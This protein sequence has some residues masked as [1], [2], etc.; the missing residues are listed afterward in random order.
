[1]RLRVCV[2]GDLRRALEW[3][4]RRSGIDAEELASSLMKRAARRLVRAW[5]KAHRGVLLFEPRSSGSGRLSCESVLEK[6]YGPRRAVRRAQPA[7][8]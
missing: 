5:R 7:E 2:E 8:P 3:E 1:M 6:A 4:A